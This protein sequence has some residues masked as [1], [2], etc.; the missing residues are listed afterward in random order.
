MLF[1]ERITEMQPSI[2]F[3][4]E[5]KQGEIIPIYYYEK[6]TVASVDMCMYWEELVCKY[7][8]GISVDQPQL[9]RGAAITRHS[10]LHHIAINS[11]R[12]C[13]VAE[14]GRFANFF[15]HALPV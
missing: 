13:Q 11:S 14:K 10:L 9:T 1:Y 12:G 7:W 6:H 8:V 15:K 3:H 2:T 4:R 5:V